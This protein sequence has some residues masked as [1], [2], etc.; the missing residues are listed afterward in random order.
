MILILPEFHCRGGDGAAISGL[1]ASIKCALE[2]EPSV[3]TRSLNFRVLGNS[4]VIEGVLDRPGGAEY[5]R[6]LAEAIAGASRVIVRI[7]CPPERA[8]RQNGPPPP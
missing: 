3:E 7:S 1:V 6:Q 8:A 4:V 2:A 5:V